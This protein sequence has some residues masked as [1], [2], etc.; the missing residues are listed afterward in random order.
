[1]GEWRLSG[2]G[3]PLQ[4]LPC[5]LLPL[6]AVGMNHR[7]RLMDHRSCMR[8]SS[9]TVPGL[10]NQMSHA[11]PPVRVGPLAFPDSQSPRGGRGHVPREE[12]VLCKGAPG[13]ASQGVPHR[14]EGRGS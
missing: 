4:L 8:Y 12:L 6:A 5:F 1:M 9:G 13:A 3:S 10:C 14:E 7:W 2:C 11:A